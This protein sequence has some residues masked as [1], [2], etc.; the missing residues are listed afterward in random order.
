MSFCRCLWS[1][2][3][4]LL[5]LASG[6]S[7]DV[8]VVGPP[9]A[10]IQKAIDEASYGDVVQLSPG[11]YTEEIKV[12][13]KS[14]SIVGAGMEMTTIRSPDAKTHIV[15]NFSHEGI[16][17]WC[18]VLVDNQKASFPQTVNI[19]DLKVD[20]STQ[21][22]TQILPVY[23][24]TDRFYGI[25]Y[26]N[27]GGTIRNVHVTNTKQCKDF[28]QTTGGGI[29]N[30]SE[31]EVVHFTVT[32]SLVDFYQRVGIDCRG[33]ALI[34]NITGNTI[35]RGHRLPV[36]MITSS[37]NGIQFSGS[38]T[39]SITNNLVKQNIAA[40][41]NAAG[42]GIFLFC[43]GPDVTVSGNAIN[44]N[45]VGISAVR[46]GDNLLIS[47][48]TLNFT[49]VPSGINPIEGIFVQDTN[50]ITTISYNELNDI[51]DVSI[52]LKSVTNQHFDLAYNQING[53]KIGFAI[54]G[55]TNAGPVITMNSDSFAGAQE[56]Y[57]QKELSPNDIWLSTASVSFD[58]LVPGHMTEQEFSRV[59]AKIFD[60]HN[61]STLGLVLDYIAP[62][63]PVLTNISPA[64]GS[65]SG[66]NRVTITGSNFLS[67]QT[68]VHF[69]S[70]ATS[71]MTVISDGLIVAIV[72]PGK[73]IVDVTVTTPF[74]ISA[75]TPASRYKYVSSAPIPP[76]NFEGTIKETDAGYTLRA[77]WQASPTKDV[78]L[79]R[80]YKQYKII[81][82]IPA[83][84]FLTF[85]R[86]VCAV[87][88]V[89]H[90]EI[91]AVGANDV[92]STRVK[93]K[94]QN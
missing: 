54:T 19:S 62:V 64:I 47:N 13:S 33:A 41:N 68:D 88:A 81:A 17:T 63:G 83:S 49:M 40:V 52:S 15:Q 57:I 14:I 73:G 32:D 46:C 78:V 79:Y 30:A 38:A 43:A 71:G 59:L 27:A 20:G 25:A 85:K 87:N 28:T 26:H 31:R 8:I 36:G 94:I 67:S 76:S 21:Q 77:K 92:E 82:E 93:I 69:G 16:N 4:F 24:S 65:V 70:I 9:P 86:P 61:D 51:P 12:I 18:V 34:A 90:Y 11:I 22:D 23:G 42:S 29:L 53:S 60:W 91:V 5:F 75:I 7:A 45:D 39:G 89:E 44:N 72:P 37:P 48:N 50:G 1:S 55:N 80:I 66:G 35:D 2:F 74:G 10:S 6:L 3:C 84:D 56:Y 58:G